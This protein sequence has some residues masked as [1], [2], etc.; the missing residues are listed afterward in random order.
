MRRLS[1]V[2][3]T[4]NVFWIRAEIFRIACGALVT[5]LNVRETTL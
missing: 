2:I 1:A 5:N 3:T 4:A